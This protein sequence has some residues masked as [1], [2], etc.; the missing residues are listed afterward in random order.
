MLVSIVLGPNFE[1][2]GAVYMK[3]INV[4]IYVSDCG[5]DILFF[6]YLHLRK[7]ILINHNKMK[8][9]LDWAGSG[10]PP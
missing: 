3:N 10:Y 5:L 9:L 6:E 8:I 1:T 2:L 4:N 7:I